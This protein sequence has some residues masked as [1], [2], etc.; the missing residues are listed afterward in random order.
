M[1]WYINLDDIIFTTLK[2]RVSNKLKSKYPNIN[3]TTS[4]MNNG[5]PIFPTVLFQVLDGKELM[6]SLESK[7]VDSVIIPIQIDVYTNTSQADAKKISWAIMEEM[8]KLSFFC[9]QI[10]TFKNDTGIY[11]QVSRY[12]RTFYPGDSIIL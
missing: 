12:V 8:K 1:S 10:P 9:E 5:N 2:I 4:A 3:F 7:A 11:R 6:K